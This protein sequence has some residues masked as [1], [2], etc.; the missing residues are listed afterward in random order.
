MQEL[1]KELQTTL[2]E[3]FYDLGIH[4]HHNKR[5]DD[6]GN[7]YIVY[8]IVSMP[9]IEY[10]NNKPILQEQNVDVNYYAMNDS[11]NASRIN[12]IQSA[13]FENGWKLT[14]GETFIYGLPDDLKGITMEF[15]REQVL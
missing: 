12:L 7:E 3:F 14:T 13:M 10:A 4:S 8:N 1:A 2:D 15:T 6:I 9:F 11:Y 5:K